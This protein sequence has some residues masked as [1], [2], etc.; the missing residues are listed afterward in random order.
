MV[1]SLRK[2]KLCCCT[3]NVVVQRIQKH[4]ININYK[5]QEPYKKFKSITFWK[6]MAEQFNP[7]T[8]NSYLILN[9]LANYIAYESTTGK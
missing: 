6:I 3:F 1:F 2:M 5:A 9:S 7:H 8:L 4:F